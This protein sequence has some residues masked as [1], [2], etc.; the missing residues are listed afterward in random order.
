M[1]GRNELGARGNTPC[2][3]RAGLAAPDQLPGVFRATLVHSVRTGLL[4]FAQSRALIMQIQAVS[5]LSAPLQDPR[6]ISPSSHP[7][8]SPRPRDAQ[9][10]AGRL[11][12]QEDARTA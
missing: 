10:E 1:Y 3:D 12:L 7:L 4:V 8:T 9:L 2:P 11:H 5:L 6:V